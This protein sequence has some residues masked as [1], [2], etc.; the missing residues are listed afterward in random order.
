MKDLFCKLFEKDPS[1]RITASGILSHPWLNKNSQITI[2]K[3]EKSS[4]IFSC[5]SSTVRK[6]LHL[7]EKANSGNSKKFKKKLRD[8]VQVKTVLSRKISTNS[9]IEVNKSSTLIQK[10]GQSVTAIKA[11]NQ[12][13]TLIKIKPSSNSNSFSSKVK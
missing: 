8:S 4:S 6:F 7:E 9:K 12:I 2:Q 11:P 10:Q 3:Q 5:C 13:S 1:K